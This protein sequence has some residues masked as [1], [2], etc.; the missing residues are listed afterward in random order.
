MIR[1]FIFKSVLIYDYHC[2]GFG[3]QLPLLLPE[4]GGAVRHLRPLVQV[5]AG[6]AGGWSVT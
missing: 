5:A 1:R 2:P 3:D 6:E 4:R